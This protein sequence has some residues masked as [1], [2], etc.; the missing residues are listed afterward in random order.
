[1]YNYKIIYYWKLSEIVD[2]VT[3]WEILN[4]KKANNVNLFF[5]LILLHSLQFQCWLAVVNSICLLK[6][7]AYEK[8]LQNNVCWNDS[9]FGMMVVKYVFDVV[10]L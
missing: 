3:G 4:K 9:L 8:H 10:K 2:F 5:L 6:N 7:V 1:M